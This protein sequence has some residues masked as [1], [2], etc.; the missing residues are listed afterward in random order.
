[1]D[2]PN[3]PEMKEKPQSVWFLPPDAIAQFIPKDT[4]PDQI[5]ATLRRELLGG[6]LIARGIPHYA[7]AD[8]NQPVIIYHAQWQTLT[9]V[10][11][12]FSHA[13]SSLGPAHS[14]DNLEIAKSNN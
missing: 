4:P 9:I 14:Y 13:V 12:D 5:A 1:M 2:A 6:R 8:N 10:G 11:A 3:G 7:A